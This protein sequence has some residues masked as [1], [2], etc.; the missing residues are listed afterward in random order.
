[1]MP[2]NEDAW[3][4]LRTVEANDKSDFMSESASSATYTP[5]IISSLYLRLWYTRS[6][7]LNLYFFAYLYKKDRDEY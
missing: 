5:I 2:E 1:M 6:T 3:Q 4:Y 7:I